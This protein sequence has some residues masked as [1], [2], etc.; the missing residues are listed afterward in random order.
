[1]GVGAEARPLR[2]LRVEPSLL[3]RGYEAGFG[4]AIDVPD[5]DVGVTYIALGLGIGIGL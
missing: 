4:F 2:W 5:R 1:M 3:L